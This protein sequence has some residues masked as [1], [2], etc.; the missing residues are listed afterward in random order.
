MCEDQAQNHLLSCTTPT[1][2]HLT[3]LGSSRAPLSRSGRAVTQSDR[4][5]RLRRGTFTRTAKAAARHHRRRRAA[6]VAATSS[7]PFF[8]PSA[9]IFCARAPPSS[10]RW[11]AYCLRASGKLGRA[12][13]PRGPAHPGALSSVLT[14]P[15][16]DWTKEHG[17]TSQLPGAGE[18]EGRRK[19][20]PRL[21]P[22]PKTA[23]R[24]LI[25]TKR[26]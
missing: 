23:G 18:E 8:A 10:R 2:D 22:A 17:R 16:G 5:Y 15:P 19:R 9:P 13:A 14:S 24:S 21:D 20:L 7:A 26:R 3:A 11:L 12:G 25:S 4:P 6:G 1:S